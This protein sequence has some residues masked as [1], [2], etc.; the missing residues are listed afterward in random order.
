[1][2][3]DAFPEPRSFCRPLS[4]L[5]YWSTGKSVCT[6]LSSIP[7]LNASVRRKRS[8]CNAPRALI[9]YRITGSVCDACKARRSQ[10]GSWKYP[11]MHGAVLE[12]KKSKVLFSRALY[13]MPNDT[14]L[15]G[16]CC[17]RTTRLSCETGSEEDLYPSHFL[18]VLVHLPHAGFASSH[19]TLRIL[20]NH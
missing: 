14:P 19:F 2:L 16:A 12:R 7:D 11:D 10:T 17:T 20:F 8:S 18:P 1:M 9:A 4:A 15:E 5:A 3:V 6:R 13:C